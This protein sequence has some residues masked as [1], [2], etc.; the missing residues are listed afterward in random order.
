MLKFKKFIFFILLFTLMTN[1]FYISSGTE[2][3][4][5]S[6]LYF[7]EK[8]EYESKINSTN[9]SLDL[10]TLNLFNIDE[11]GDL[12]LTNVIDKDT[13]KLMHDNDVKIIP[14]IS[15]HW[16]REIG[17]KALDNYKNICDKMVQ[18][19][20]DLNLDG[21][22]IDL[23]NLTKNEKDKLL[24]FV[25]YLRDKLPKD[26]E[27]SI[28][29]AANPYEIDF[30][31]QGSYDYEELGKI[32]DYIVL[33]TYDE[34][35]WGSDPGPVA[36]IDFVEDSIKHI[37][38]KVPSNKVLL[39]IPFYGRYWNLDKSIGGSGFPLSMINTLT[40][41]YSI[42]NNYNSIYKS[43]YITFKI[44]QN[45]PD[46]YV[47]GNLLGLGNYVLWYE[48]ESSIKS[49]LILVEKYDL[50]GTASWSLGQEDE[51]IWKHYNDWLNGSY[52][53]DTADSWAHDEINYVTVNGLMEGIN[54]T[55]FSPKANLTRSQMAAVLC[56]L[57]NLNINK[58]E[59]S[60]FND[61]DKTLWAYDYINTVQSYGI[62]IGNN[63]NFNPNNYISR[64]EASAVFYRILDGYETSYKSIF[65]DV[66]KGSWS[67]NYI[68]FCYENKIFKGYTDNT[69]KPNNFLTRDEIATLLSRI[70]D[71]ITD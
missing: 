54:T 47:Y 24:T 8:E 60:P 64:E 59:K 35:Y 30:G 71:L 63:N 45:D 29:V 19:V 28:A 61:V 51:S 37:T 16:N 62:M 58:I 67:E 50:K 14:F 31:W 34:S 66:E 20:I 49:K 26:K 44:N 36:S 18:A 13:V 11:N 6:Y 57:L 65:K 53:I 15:N 22:N 33:M 41:T 5:M 12:I 46:F 39:G 52:Y 7:P 23:E 21:I 48:N 69:F 42:Q 40:N 32:C 9:N 68:M 4:N 25:K 56:R 70:N 38:K 43:P 55:E 3:I 1:M 17:I 27:L 2:K 10:V